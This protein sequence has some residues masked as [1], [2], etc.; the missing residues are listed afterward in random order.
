MPDKGKPG[1]LKFKNDLFGAVPRMEEGLGP[2]LKSDFDIR[3]LIEGN[4]ANPFLLERF[5]PTPITFIAAGI[6]KT[7]RIPL[8]TVGKKRCGGQKRGNQKKKHRRKRQFHPTVPIRP[9]IGT[10]R[11]A[12]K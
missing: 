10:L 1:I 6:I 3:F 7:G 11:Y 12:E 2:L 8:E 4:P 9:T 5:T